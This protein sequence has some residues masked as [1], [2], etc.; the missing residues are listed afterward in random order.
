MV[1]NVSFTC[2]LLPHKVR[3]TFLELGEKEHYLYIEFQV[4]LSSFIAILLESQK[5]L[6]E[7]VKY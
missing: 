3:E 4:N 2:S 7:E 1:N 5:E 6:H